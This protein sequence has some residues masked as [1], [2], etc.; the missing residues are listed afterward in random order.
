MRAV[1][2]TC[3]L[4]LGNTQNSNSEKSCSCFGMVHSY[5][6]YNSEKSVLFSFHSFAVLDKAVL[7]HVVLHA[8]MSMRVLGGILHVRAVEDDR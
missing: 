6:S 4:L 7:N 5:A 3:T 8:S 2:Y 1:Y